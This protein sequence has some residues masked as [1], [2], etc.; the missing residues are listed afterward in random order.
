MAKEIPENQIHEID[1]EYLH[2]LTGRD[3]TVHYVQHGT[4]KTGDTISGGAKGETGLFQ[5]DLASADVSAGVWDLEIISD[6]GSVKRALE[7]NGED[8][9]DVGDAESID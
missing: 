8:Q 5:T 7:I 4:V 9:I 6:D 3:L 1:V 2:D